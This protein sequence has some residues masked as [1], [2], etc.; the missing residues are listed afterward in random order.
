MNVLVST[1]DDRPHCGSDFCDEWIKDGAS[2]EK[3]VECIKK[4]LHCLVKI[5]T[6][7][8]SGKFCAF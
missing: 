2:L 1:I 8:G 4:W 6:F 3:T 5:I 7:I